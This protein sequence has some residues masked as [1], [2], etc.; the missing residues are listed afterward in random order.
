MNITADQVK[1]MRFI[2]RAEGYTTED[3][4][5][6]MSDV[7]E[8]YPIWLEFKRIALANMRA[9]IF[10][11]KRG[12]LGQMQILGEI[13]KMCPDRGN[14]PYEVNNNLAPI[15]ARFFNA[16]AKQDYFE[17]RELKQKVAA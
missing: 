7:N 2:L 10:P 16:I 12:Y 9:N 8:W 15:F 14:K 13:R 1:L 3:V 4:N 5:E 11:G 6:I 17:L